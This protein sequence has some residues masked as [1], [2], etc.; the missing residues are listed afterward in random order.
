MKISLEISFFL[1]FSPFDKN[2][3]RSWYL[4]THKLIANEKEDL[5]LKY[6]EGG[7]VFSQIPSFTKNLS[8]REIPFCYPT[9]IS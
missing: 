5:E 7:W 2:R 8:N 6:Q 9:G 4:T 3:K 1:S